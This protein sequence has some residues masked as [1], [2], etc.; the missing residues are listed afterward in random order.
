[1]TRE[2]IAGLSQSLVPSTPR[3]LPLVVCFVAVSALPA[4]AEMSAFS[5]WT[6]G[7]AALVRRVPVDGQGLDK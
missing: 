5:M 1:M 3:H 4:V 6:T 2:L 7:L